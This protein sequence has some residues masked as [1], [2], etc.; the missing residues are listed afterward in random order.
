MQP[1]AIFIT[2]KQSYNF[3]QPLQNVSSSSKFLEKPSQI[4]GTQNT[5]HPCLHQKCYHGNPWWLMFTESFN[6]RI[7]WVAS[8][9]P[10]RNGATHD[11]PHT[12]NPSARQIGREAWQSRAHPRIYAEPSLLLY[13]PF[14]CVSRS[15]T[16]RCWTNLRNFFEHASGFTGCMHNQLR[17]KGVDQHWI[18]M[19]NLKKNVTKQIESLSFDP[20]PDVPPAWN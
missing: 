9:N 2:W 19:I 20:P 17:V 14:F 11:T 6:C 16:T 10:F 13:D 15:P 5:Q 1:E 18:V 7:S 3:I 4:F 12:P 8:K